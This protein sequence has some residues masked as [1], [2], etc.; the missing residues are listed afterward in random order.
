MKLATW[1]V[2]GI[3][4]ATDKGLRQ[5][6]QTELPDIICLQE[7]KAHPDQVNTAW[8]DD[9]GYHAI[10]NAA[11]RKG[12][13][14][15]LVW[16]RIQPVR[17]RLGLG[18]AD[19][20]NEGRVITTTFDDFTLI[21]VYTPNSQNEL[22]RLPYRAQWD[23]AFADF[24]RRRNR[25]H[26]V[27]ICGDLNVAHKEIDLANPKTNRKTPGFTDQER[28]AMD[29]LIDGGMIDTFRQFNDRPGQYSWWSYRSGA[30]ARNVGWRLDYFL[31]ARRLMPAVRSVQIRPDIHGSDHCPVEMVIEV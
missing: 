3:R 14:G 9:L 29:R 15:T 30:R 26:P 1:N 17:H 31:T 5:Y 8:A 27:I 11:A 10:W 18:I 24:V 23:E 16:S 2:N 20:D 25:R 12:Y 7:T 21:N 22:K 4:A 13:S 6:V 28:Q 19:H